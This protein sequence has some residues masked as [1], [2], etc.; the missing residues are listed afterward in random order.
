[1]YIFTNRIPEGAEGNDFTGVSL[2]TVGGRVGG[3]GVCLPLVPLHFLENPP[4]PQPSMAPS[5]G[6]RLWLEKECYAAVGTPIAVRQEDCLVQ[7][8]FTSTE[9]N[10]MLTLPFSYYDTACKLS[11]TDSSKIIQVEKSVFSQFK[12]PPNY[13]LPQFPSG[14]TWDAQTRD[15]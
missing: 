15:C 14:G 9:I 3:W 10:T 4:W 13:Q 1:M 11:H 6:P 5:P 7:N 8:N 2:L 12:D